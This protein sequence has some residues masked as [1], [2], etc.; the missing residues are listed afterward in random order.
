MIGNANECNHSG[1]SSTAVSFLD[2]GQAST[3]SQGANFSFVH[4]NLFSTRTKKGSTCLF[5]GAKIWLSIYMLV[6]PY[7]HHTT[8]ETP[9]HFL[10][11]SYAQ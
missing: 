11:A 5:F 3:D 8:V 1:R 9:M 4:C 2:S 7:L 10:N 6:I